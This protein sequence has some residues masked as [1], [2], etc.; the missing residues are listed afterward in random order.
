MREVLVIEPAREAPGIPRPIAYGHG[1]PAPRVRGLHGLLDLK[2]EVVAGRT[3]LTAIRQRPPL[4]VL[5]ALHLD[6]AVP[7]LAA[8][9]IASPSGGVLQGDH[10]ETRIE[11]A[12]GARLHVGTQSATRIYR[13]PEAP[14]QIRTE[15]IVQ[16]AG[17]L[18][19]I[20]DA[21]LPFAASRL[22][23]TMI[24]RVASDATALLGEV[25]TGGRLARGEA[26]DLDKFESV[27]EV[28]RLDDELLARDVLR[29]GA[30]E[31]AA[32]LGRLGRNLA[33]GTLFVIHAGFGAD[34]LR[35]RLDVAG[36]AVVAGAS[37]LPNGAGAWLRV[38]APDGRAAS[39]VVA[40]GWTAARL[41]ILG[42]AP[43]LDRRL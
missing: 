40:A 2:A 16:S 3:R 17:Y 13:C 22:E 39:A 25:V 9:T 20:P 6:T 38:L 32:R 24:C 42:S 7:D 18:E 41:A 43:A 23:A 26:F 27:I 34:I 5:R 37:D 36:A 28:R 14:A 15:L 31:P 4:Q 11:I 10:L 30:S 8:I 33:V 21:Y 29:L 19:Y 1:L 12:S 35:D